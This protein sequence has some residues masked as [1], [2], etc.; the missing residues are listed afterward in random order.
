MKNVKEA[1]KTLEEKMDEI[2]ELN[3]T[4]SEIVIFY[5]PKN[6]P[7]EPYFAQIECH[8]V[9]GWV[10]TI[11]GKSCGVGLTLDECLEDLLREVRIKK[12]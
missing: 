10:H 8:Y 6:D 7:Q 1:V 9:D 2:I 12:Q 3:G 11:S 5:D 4:D